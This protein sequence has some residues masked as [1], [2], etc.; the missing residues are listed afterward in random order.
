LELHIFYFQT[1]LN[2]NWGEKSD[3]ALWL[4]TKMSFCEFKF[5][6]W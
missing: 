4:G 5:W 6:E 2:S 3:S 1:T